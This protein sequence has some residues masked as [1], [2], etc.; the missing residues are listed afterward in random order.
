LQ[1]GIQEVRKTVWLV[2]GGGGGGG[3]VTYLQKNSAKQREF[4]FGRGRRERRGRGQTEGKKGEKDR[5]GKEIGYRPRKGGDDKKR[6]RDPSPGP[7]G[8]EKEPKQGVVGADRCLGRNI[9]D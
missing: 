9:K 7:E 8:G 3:G 1:R 5:T 6:G 2:S 4:V